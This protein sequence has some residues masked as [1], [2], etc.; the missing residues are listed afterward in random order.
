[1]NK[2]II[3]FGLGALILLGVTSCEDKLED[4]YLNPERT[5][6]GS[7]EKF[8]TAILDNNRVRPQYWEIRTFAGEHTAKYTQTLTF[9][10]AP[11]RYQ[12]NV[13]YLEQRWSDYFTRSGNGSGAVAHYR[14]IEKI[15][16]TLSDEQKAA[17]E[18][19]VQ[20]SKVVYLDQT[21]QMV[22]LWGDLPFSEAG[23]LNS[24]GQVV[25]P[26]FD[27]A[28]DIY[29]EALEQL[30]A[31]STFFAN[32]SLSAD[33]QKVFTK[34]DILLG[35]DVSKWRRYVNSL[36]LR[37]L[38]RI[39]FVDENRARTEVLE[40]LNNPAQYPLVDAAQYN[41]LLKPLTNY[42]GDLSNALLEGA[43]YA[44]PEFMLEN[45]L[46][47]VA[48]P[49][50]RVL[51]D[52]GVH[53]VSGTVTEPNDDYYS[54]P[55]DATSEEQS[56][57]LTNGLY[58][59]LDST[60]FIF[61]RYLP[62]TVMGSA[63]VNFIKAEAYERW[64]NTA[65][66][67]AAYVAAVEQSI[68]FYFYLSGLGSGTET[69]PTADELSD[70]WANEEVAYTGT[71]DEKLAKI[72]TQK[73]VNFGFLQSLQAWAEMRRTNY[74]QLSFTSDS[75]TPSAILPPTGRLIYPSNEV[76]YNTSNYQDIED[77]DNINTKIFWD[78]N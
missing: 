4:K 58:A 5:T 12:L 18:V 19:F 26:K 15:Y 10:N 77:K 2:N 75:S 28:Q 64:G 61:N 51:F 53:R 55:I 63:E 3:N 21:A 78:V 74:P 37:L 34:Q 76:I 49:R 24:T 65:D 30:E 57:I 9:L 1:M 8:F 68:A 60:T 44:A 25:L 29:N 41:V 69:T 42:T 46:R 67:E 7:I 56:T 23:L 20:A 27:N 45:V 17:N 35:G 50:I 32:A 36:R 47:P 72:W 54:L 22:D 39:S 59:P 66:A 16:S 70:F 62:G 40:I 33:V 14:E 13:G 48:D 6:E 11:R 31:A 71:T 52:K 73:W 38:M 43:A